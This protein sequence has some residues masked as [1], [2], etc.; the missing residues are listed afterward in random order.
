MAFYGCALW[1]KI[2]FTKVEKKVNL[3][4]RK[5]NFRDPLIYYWKLHSQQWETF[6][7]LK[8]CLA[9]VEFVWSPLFFCSQY[10]TYNYCDLI[11]LLWKH[12]CYFSITECRSKILLCFPRSG[13]KQSKCNGTLFSGPGLICQRPLN[14][15]HLH[16][17]CYT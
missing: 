3:I 6:K 17:Y 12:F 16:D 15:I 1:F 11:C 7:L 4:V 10:W 2:F 5:L 8:C 9:L 14:L 13:R